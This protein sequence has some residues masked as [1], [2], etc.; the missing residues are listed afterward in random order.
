MVLEER[1]PCIF[2]HT[3]F[4]TKKEKMG[5]IQK[6]TTSL[7]SEIKR[8]YIPIFHTDGGVHKNSP[9]TAM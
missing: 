4:H 6:K 7:I 1:N 8:R 9:T 5:N 3:T 2:P